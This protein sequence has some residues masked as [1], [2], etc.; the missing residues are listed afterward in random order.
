MRTHLLLGNEMGRLDEILASGAGLVFL[1]TPTNPTPE[2]LDV[3]AIVRMAHAHG[4]LVAVNNTFASPVNQRPLELGAD[5]AVRSCTK[6]LGGHSDL[7]AGAIMGSKDLLL[8]IW[9]WRKNLGT[10]IAPEIAG[11]LARGLRSPVIRVRQQNSGAQT[12]AEAMARHPRIARVLYPG[13]PNFPGHDLAA[14]QMSGF[15]G[16]LTIEVKGGGEEATRRSR[17]CSASS[18]RP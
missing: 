4:A 13:L 1:E 16:M 2:I 10:T 6:Y 3:H 17:P 11:L 9:N 7:T 18:P 14:R 12:V 15:G 8:P 5:F